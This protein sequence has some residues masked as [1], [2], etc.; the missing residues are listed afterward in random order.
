[1]AHPYSTQARV[2]LY[3]GADRVTALG[4]RDDSGAIDSGLMTAALERVAN[5]I[6]GAL[7]VRYSVPFASLTDT[8]GQIQDL[9]D[10]GVGALLYEWLAP[11]SPDAKLLRSMFEEQLKAYRD[12]QEVV[13]DADLLSDSADARRPMTY[14]SAGTTFAGRVDDDYTTEGVDKASN[15]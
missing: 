2:E 9:T 1:M 15:F 8:P 4:D 11:A 3:L 12:G 6:D 5:R 13:V 10:V 7:G 14:E